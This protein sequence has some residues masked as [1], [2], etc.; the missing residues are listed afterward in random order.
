LS[1][2]L[3]QPTCPPDGRYIRISS[4]KGHEYYYDC[5]DGKL[6]EQKCPEHQIYSASS[7]ICENYPK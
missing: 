7:M 6:N 1:P 2:C 5:I 4:T 3:G